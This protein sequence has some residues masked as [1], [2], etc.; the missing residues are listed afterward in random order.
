MWHNETFYGV[1]AVKVGF[2]S[3]KAHVF[4]R[5]HVITT[6]Q[7]QQYTQF[8]GRLNLHIPLIIFI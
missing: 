4:N 3:I 7:N 1:Y 6:S 5:Y 2:Q 8:E